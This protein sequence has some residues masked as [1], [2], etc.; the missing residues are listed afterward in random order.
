V[1]FLQPGEINALVRTSGK[2][3]AASEKAIGDRGM[4]RSDRCFKLL[5]TLSMRKGN[6]GKFSA[7]GEET[8]LD[9]GVGCGREEGAM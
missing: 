2:A 1:F 9:P 8:V 6:A 5:K 3:S 4:F 7:G